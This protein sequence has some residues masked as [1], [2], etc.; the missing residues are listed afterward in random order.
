MFEKMAITTIQLTE[1]TKTK[2]K[3]LGKKGDT[4]EDIILKLI[5][6]IEK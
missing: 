4:Y 1:K 3:K 5:G 6:E 2:L